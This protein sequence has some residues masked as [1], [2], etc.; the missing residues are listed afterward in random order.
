MIFIG[1][2]KNKLNDKN[3]WLSITSIIIISNIAIRIKLG[4]LD[5]NLVT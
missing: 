3:P 5:T 4:S 2:I 1:F